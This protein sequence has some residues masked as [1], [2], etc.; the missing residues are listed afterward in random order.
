VSGATASVSCGN[1]YATGAISI[2]SIGSIGG[3]DCKVAAD[4]LAD[5]VVEED[6]FGFIGKCDD[7]LPSIVDMLAVDGDQSF[8]ATDCA[9]YFAYNMDATF[10]TLDGND[11][12]TFT[13]EG[14]DSTQDKLIF[15]NADAVTRYNWLSE[16]GHQ[17]GDTYYWD[18]NGH[19]TR[20]NQYAEVTKSGVSSFNVLDRTSVNGRYTTSKDV[21]NLLSES[22]TALEIDAFAYPDSVTT[23]D[24]LASS[25]LIYMGD[26]DFFH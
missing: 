26:P 2:G 19:R 22:G 4:Q 3:D 25:V 15:I 9:D 8:Q 13:I 17:E 6:G 24:D 18:H 12:D 1:L 23:P 16:R 11:I 14:F 20:Y 7:T 5:F 21:I 10:R